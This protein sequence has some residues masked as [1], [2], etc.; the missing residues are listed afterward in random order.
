MPDDSEETEATRTQRDLVSASRSLVIIFG[1]G[2]VIVVSVIIFVMRH[3]PE[4][5]LENGYGKPA[6][7]IPRRTIARP[8][9]KFGALCE[10][11]PGKLGSCMQK[12]NC[13]GPGCLFCQSQH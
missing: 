3:R 9:E 13:T 11:S 5:N 10:L 2:A 4:G 7:A 6:P 1:I 8:C 12:E